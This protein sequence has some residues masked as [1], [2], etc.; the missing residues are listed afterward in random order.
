V[1]GI[2]GKRRRRLLLALALLTLAAG[3]VS[4]GCPSTRHQIYT[5]TVTGTD[6]ARSPALTHSAAV[7]LVV[8]AV[9]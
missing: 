7:S 2:P 3:L 8:A 1:V 6:S 5:I 9:D 4:C